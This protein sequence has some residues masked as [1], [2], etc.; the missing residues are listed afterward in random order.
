MVGYPFRAPASRSYRRPLSAGVI[1]G[2]SASRS[3]SG[4]SCRVDQY[5][6]IAPAELDLENRLRRRPCLAW[7]YSTWPHDGGTI[8]RRRLERCEHRQRAEQ[9]RCACAGA[10]FRWPRGRTRPERSSSKST[11]QIQMNIRPKRNRVRQGNR[12]QRA[13]LRHRRAPGTLQRLKAPHRNRGV[14]PI[15]PRPGPSAQPPRAA[16]N[17][18]AMGHR[19]D[20]S[21]LD[22]VVNE[23]GTSSPRILVDRNHITVPLALSVHSE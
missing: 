23:A 15:R 3:A 8:G 9:Y 14:M 7:K 1:H 4:S 10:F 2:Y 17:C 11:P 21:A 16:R 22:A 6:A 5:P 19:D 13:S 18:S 20:V 12:Q